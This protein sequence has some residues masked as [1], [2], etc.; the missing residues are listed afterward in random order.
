ME[1]GETKKRHFRLEG[2]RTGS[3]LARL[4]SLSLS[5]SEIYIKISNVLILKK[6]K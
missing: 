2:T 3:G 4:L 5:S 1:A 6:R